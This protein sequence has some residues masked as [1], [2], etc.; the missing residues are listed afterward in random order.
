MSLLCGVHHKEFGA[1]FGFTKH[2]STL[3]C[4]AFVANCQRLFRPEVCIGVVAIGTRKHFGCRS[5]Q[6]WWEI[7][8]I[9]HKAINNGKVVIY[10]GCY[11]LQ[12]VFEYI[13]RGSDCKHHQHHSNKTKAITLW[14]WPVVS[15]RK[16]TLIYQRY[17]WYNPVQAFWIIHNCSVLCATMSS[18]CA[19]HTMLWFKN[20]ENGESLQKTSVP[21]TD[22]PICIHRYCSDCTLRLHFEHRGIEIS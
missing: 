21:L 14:Y 17:W 22:E 4:W 15:L 2:S 20:G 5:L 9:A 13:F 7:A 19:K 1:I 10:C 12:K 6:D 18:N 8:W 3:N 11:G 16:K